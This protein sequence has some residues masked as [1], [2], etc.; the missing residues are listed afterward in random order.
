MNE[1]DCGPITLNNIKNYVF[2]YG[3]HNNL[4]NIIHSIPQ[5]DDINHENL[6]EN[7][8]IDHIK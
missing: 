5:Y 2:H 4:D 7:Y 1:W 8:R 3:Q 6:L